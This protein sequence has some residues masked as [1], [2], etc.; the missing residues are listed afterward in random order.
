MTI[1]PGDLGPECAAGLIARRLGQSGSAGPV[2]EPR[3]QALAR[4]T[5]MDEP[6]ATRVAK[7]TGAFFST[8][9][10][11]LS[12]ALGVMFGAPALMAG[13]LGHAFIP[14]A[15]LA[16][17]S[18]GGIVL[19]RTFPHRTLRRI[20]QSAVAEVEIEA[21]LTEAHDPL[22]KT[23]LMLLRDALRHTELPKPAEEELR[24]ALRALGEAIEHLPAPEGIASDPDALRTEADVLRQQGLSEPDQTI[25]ESLLRQADARAR[26]AE[27]VARAQLALRRSA[28]LRDELSA[29]A[30]ALRIG[31]A[32]QKPEQKNASS[33]LAQLAESARRVAAEAVSLADARIEI[34]CYGPAPETEVQR[35][36]SGR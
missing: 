17:L 3:Q 4:S 15:I 1:L 21:F 10:N 2:P 23:Y 12:F 5:G 26:S 18:A 11:L 14:A 35:V 27:S 36:K 9:A 22:E 7:R 16:T 6:A 34:E 31:L 8:Q 25:S 33:E 29:Q 30:E 28:T 32:A 20:C 19:G 24:A 13:G